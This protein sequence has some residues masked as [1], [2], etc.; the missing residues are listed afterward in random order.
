MAVP[1]PE[2]PSVAFIHQLAKERLTTFEQ[3]SSVA[4]YVRF[5][6]NVREMTGGIPVGFKLSANHIER[7]IQFALDAGAD[8]IIL[9]GRGGGTG[10]A[11]LMFRDHISVPTIPA[12]LSGVGYAGYQSI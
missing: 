1:T 9:D 12:R 7:D 11:P 6:D 8:Y 3:L 5:A 2:E 10:A 4:D